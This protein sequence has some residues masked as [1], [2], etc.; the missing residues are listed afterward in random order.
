LERPYD[1]TKFQSVD[2]ELFWPKGSV[3]FV[4]VGH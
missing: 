1:N 3:V 2:A 4:F